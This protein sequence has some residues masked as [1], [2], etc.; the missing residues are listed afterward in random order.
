MFKSWRAVAVLI[1]FSCISPLSL[2]ANARSLPAG[3]EALASKSECAHYSWKQRGKAPVGYIEGVALVYAN[4]Y[5]DLKLGMEPT[6]TVVAGAAPNMSEDAL[7]LYGEAGGTPTDR[8]VAV[9]AL[10]IGEGMRESSGNTTEGPDKTVKH[11]TGEIA[12]AGLYQISHNSLGKSPWLAII[13][14]QFA[15]H[16]DLCLLQVF[17][18]GIRDRNAPIVGDGAGADFQRQMK[19]CPAF[20][21]EYVAVMLRVNRAHF[22]PVKRREAELVPICKAMLMD[23]GRIV[24]G[25]PKAILR[26]ALKN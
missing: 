4:A 25:S 1:G 5:R 19:S 23:V 12:E 6:A 2:G 3:I 17:I 14:S 24:D 15:A 21:T 9:Y 22:G 20:A 16:S 11:Q 26:N 10:A 8:L 7:E 18:R 13:Q